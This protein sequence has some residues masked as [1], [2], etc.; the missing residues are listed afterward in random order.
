MAWWRLNGGCQTYTSCFRINRKFVVK[1][2]SKTLRSRACIF[3][4][5]ILGAPVAILLKLVTRLSPLCWLFPSWSA[6]F[7]TYHGDYISRYGL[8]MSHFVIN[9]DDLTIAAH[10]IFVFADCCIFVRASA[11]DIFWASLASASHLCFLFVFVR[12]A[13]NGCIYLSETLKVAL[14]GTLSTTNMTWS[15]IEFVSV[16]DVAS[17]ID[18]TIFWELFY[19]SFLLELLLLRVLFAFGAK[20]LKG[21][22][23]KLM[24]L[25]SNR[26]PWI[27][28][29]VDYLPLA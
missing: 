20:A 21:A 10:V 7:W 19:D 18:L 4:T 6:A 28:L 27:H 9:Q 25:F 1:N 5:M 3:R 22:V 24:A 15:V 12:I 2:V 13:E 14:L 29:T 8:N 17:I 11:Q 16:L 23:I 26:S